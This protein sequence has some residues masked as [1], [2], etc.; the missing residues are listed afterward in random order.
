MARHHPHKRVATAAAVSI[1]TFAAAL[2]ALWCAP[3]VSDAVAV[4]LRTPLVRAATLSVPDGLGVR[5][6]SL[7]RASS[8]TTTRQSPYESGGATGAAARAAAVTL[9][10]GLRFTML[11]VTCA[12]PEHP[13]GVLID[14][15]TSLDGEHWS[16]W[17]SASLDVQ[18]DAGS[19]T[20]QA[21]TE[22]MWTGPG[23]YV[24]VAARPAAG[25]AAPASLRAVHVVAIDSTEHADA[26]A[27][28]LGVIRRT[29]ATV[30]GLGLVPPAAAMTDRPAIVTRAEW[31][32][33]ESYRTGTPDYATPVMAFVHH[34]D[35]GNDYGRS[36][37]AAVVRGAF[38]YHTRSLHWSDIGYNFLVDRYGVIYEGRYGGVTKG[39]IGAQV[40]GFNTGSIGVSMV[41]TYSKA[42]PTVASVRALESLLAW[43][44]DVHHIDP[45]GTATLTCGYGE[46]F[47]TGEAVK[48]AAISGHRDANY[49]EC[50][51]NR[52]Y[53]QLPQIRR[54]VAAMGLPKIYDVR[55]GDNPY[56]S[57]D[58]DGVRDGVTFTCRL[59]QP[60][61]WKLEVC[62][63]SGTVVRSVSGSGTA[64]E[65]TWSGH[66]NDGERVPDGE[67]TMTVAASNRD[68]EARPATQVVHV[69][70]APPELQGAAVD[71]GTFSPNGDGH[72]DEAT[73][74][75]A[76]GESGTARV[77]VLD[78]ADK[79]VRTVLPWRGVGAARKAV[80]WD[81]RINDGGTL[82]DAPEG[83]TVVLVEMRDLAGNSD[84][85]RRSVIVDR[86]LGFPTVKPASFSPNGD[87]VKDSA[88]L[89]FTLTR[90]AAVTVRALKGEETAVTIDLGTLPAGAGRASWGGELSG[91]A[92]PVSGTYRLEI[93][94]DG[95][96]G[97]SSVS[98]PVT[99]DLTAPRLTVPAEASVK[100]G[101]T[102]TLAYTVRDA[103]S[104]TVNVAVG[105]T[106]ATKAQVATLP[107]GW[108][109]RASP[110]TCSWRAPA[111]GTYT[112]TFTA[113]DRA[114]NP[115][116]APA[117]TVVTVR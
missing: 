18:A 33:D 57:P 104:P 52:L 11:G 115:Q 88:A 20:P 112:L 29:A 67:Y 51:G 2:A 25:T 77:T 60:A 90:R 78:G 81:G 45:Q 107:L 58:G 75:F 86:T 111:A 40:L 26:G 102:L 110:A 5:D 9:D 80:T 62:D 64:V 39:V 100:A 50:P 65:S 69:D 95:S 23:R 46:K 28:V 36:E 91:G 73:V 84:S 15:R 105:V 92:A 117:V 1:L 76:P 22:A 14:L 53:P 96:V 72:D 49:T 42:A 7:A 35:S 37:A 106:D 94:A 44:L 71:P 85:V 66:D 43:K 24:Q 47:A 93:V 4:W 63:S 116:Q 89:G 97:V 68:G 114:G 10:A 99:V 55:V 108:V 3:R 56:F 31:G 8:T 38:Y 27:T 61:E 30:A 48:F 101:K 54:T 13:E 21:F 16:R 82:V 79:A 6:V 87:G 103:Y 74:S 83:R 98:V 70:T 34:T 109:K 12:V 113:V 19:R 17:Y 32:A 41:G 59:S